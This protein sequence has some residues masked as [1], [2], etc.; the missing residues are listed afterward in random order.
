MAQ[1][2]LGIIAELKTF[3]SKGQVVDSEYVFKPACDWYIEKL[4]DYLGATRYT[5]IG[6][7]IDAFGLDVAEKVIQGEV[8]GV[9]R[10]LSDQEIAEKGLRQVSCSTPFSIEKIKSPIRHPWPGGS[11]EYL[12]PRWE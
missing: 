11:K 4:N 3:N 8:V 1:K 2:M 6:A 10:E 7:V 5:D 9:E 12:I